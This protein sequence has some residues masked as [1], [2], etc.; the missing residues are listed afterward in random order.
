MN[1]FYLL[2]LFSTMAGHGSGQEIDSSRIVRVLTFN[3]LH[4]ETMKGDFDLD[5]IAET[6]EAT[7]PDLVALQEVDNKTNRAKG[8][9]LATEL[10]YRTKLMSLFGAA[11]PYDGGEYGEAILSR[12][13][14]LQ[15]R[16]LGLTGSPGK[17]PRAALEVTTVLPSG[18]TITFIG[19]HLDHTRD[20]SD[21]ITQVK[22]I[23]Q[24]FS[25]NHHP[26]ILAGDLNTKP[27]SEVFNLLMSH[28]RPAFGDNPAPT[29]P[30]DGPRVKIDYI[31]FAPA[32]RW[33]VLDS[34]VI[35]APMA[36]DHCP[37]LVVLELLPDS[38]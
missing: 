15:T 10:G 9:D 11:M 20:P 38:K 37:Y 32:N 17:E 24:Y 4:G 3:I 27:D 34:Q 35:N 21:R 36:S 2:M 7:S 12:F 29:F 13:S 33:R 26:S 19:T 5:L 1:R 25:T 30:C 28:W 18:D 6:I 22:E 14:F 23:N 8:I 31:M 16:N